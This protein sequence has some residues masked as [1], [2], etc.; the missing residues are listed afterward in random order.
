MARVLP[1]P[2]ETADLGLRILEAFG[3]ARFSVSEYFVRIERARYQRL[4]DPGQNQ[5]IRETLDALASDAIGVL[6]S[7]PGP[8]GG[9]GWRLNPAAMPALRRRESVL[10]ARAAKKQQEFDA[11]AARRTEIENK[12][13]VLRETLADRF[14]GT[15]LAEPVIQEFLA[16]VDAIVAASLR[17]RRRSPS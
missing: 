12:P 17:A 5:R 14:R 2:T 15:G 4:P 6:L 8:R 3:E 16:A 13:A 9:A 7:V 11:W 1:L 10:N